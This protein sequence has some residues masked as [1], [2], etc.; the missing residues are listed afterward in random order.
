MRACVGAQEL[1]T[2]IHHEAGV[3]V[4]SSVS[5][6]SCTTFAVGGPLACLAEPQNID[7]LRRLLRFLEAQKLPWRVL[8]NGSNLLVSDSGLAECVVRLG[9]G[10]RSVTPLG[11]AEFEV[12]AGAALMTLS[13]ELSEQGYSGLE[14]AGGIP[15][16]M[17]GA[18]RMNAGAHGGE[19]AQ[20]LTRVSWVT[21]DGEEV[22]AAAAA[23]A[24]AYRRSELPPGVVVSSMVLKLTPSDAA[25]CIARRAKFLAERRAK[26]P[27][28]S[29]SAGSVFKNPSPDRS[30][31]YLIEKAGLKGRRIGGAEVSAMHANW[32]INPSRA[33]SAEDVH[34]LIKLCQD[35]V[36]AKFGVELQAEVIEWG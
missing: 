20:V 32:I 21:A 3:Y 14:F 15:A 25:E 35:E 4:R 11:N 31:G 23:L 8:G 7:E 26:Q 5:A 1:C 29:P 18:V 36:R 9:R 16:A 6:A 34:A 27:L 2:A 17:G 33:A 30:A 12:G 19:M 13:R 22:T 28:A 10:F 24:F